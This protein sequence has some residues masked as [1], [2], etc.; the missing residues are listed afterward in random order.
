[1]HIIVSFK[2][3]FQIG[4]NV[5]NLEWALAHPVLCV[6]ILLAHLHA[7]LIFK[8]LY[9]LVLVY[10]LDEVRTIGKMEVCV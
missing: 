10:N 8:E 9:I 6:R 4:M 3:T 5:M 1:M 7:C 2:L